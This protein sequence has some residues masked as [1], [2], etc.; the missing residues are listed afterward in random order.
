LAEILGSSAISSREGLAGELDEGSNSTASSLM[1]DVQ[2]DFV[3]YLQ[4]EVS[5]VD[6]CQGS[7]KEIIIL[8]CSRTTGLGF[9]VSPKRINVALTRAKR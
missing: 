7:E 4:F 5:T 2:V 9:S 3:Y 8:A 6:A 1:H